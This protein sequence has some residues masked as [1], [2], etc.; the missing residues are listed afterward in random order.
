VVHRVAAAI[1]VA[2]GVTVLMGYGDL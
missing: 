1:F 2:L